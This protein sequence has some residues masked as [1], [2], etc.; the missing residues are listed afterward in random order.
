M[1]GRN[2][3]SHCLDYSTLKT[4]N[5][6]G[7]NK[8]AWK[9]SFVSATTF[10]TTTGW[11][12]PIS[13]TDSKAFPTKLFRTW[14]LVEW[15]TQKLKTSLLVAGMVLLVSPSSEINLKQHKR[16]LKYYIK[17][18]TWGISFLVSV[19][20]NLKFR[21]K[22]WN[23]FRIFRLSSDNLFS[24]TSSLIKALSTTKDQICRHVDLE[25][26]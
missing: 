6:A 17:Q 19:R 3:A 22:N 15:T 16:I 25:R 23:E 26:T 12:L 18:F 24:Q 10:S 4:L 5:V 14:Y 2:V 11:K 21:I 20:E 1:T 13:I 8:N 7:S 9:K